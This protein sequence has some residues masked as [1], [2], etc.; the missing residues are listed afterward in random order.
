MSGNNKHKNLNH[1]LAKLS[2]LIP[3][4]SDRHGIFAQPGD[5]LGILIFKSSL[6]SLSGTCLS[7]YLVHHTPKNILPTFEGLESSPE[8]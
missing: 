8:P 4:V 1:L 2:P 7:P 5:K 6:V 3:T